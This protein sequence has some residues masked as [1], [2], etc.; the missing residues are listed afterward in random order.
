MTTPITTSTTDSQMHN[1]IMA[2]G[3]R[4]RP[5]ML[6]TRPNGEALSKFILEGP[7]KLTTITIPA[8]HATDDT[9]AVPERTAEAIHLLRTG[10]GDEIYSTVDAFKI[11]HDIWIAIERLQQDPYYQAPKSQKAYATHPKQPSSTRSSETTNYKGK[12]IAKPIIP[13]SE[14]ASEEDSDPE[15]AQRDK[16][17]QKNLALIA[18]YFKKIYKPTNNNLITSSNSRKKNVDT[19]PRYKN[20]NQSG[21]FGNQK[22]VT[23][24]GARETICSQVVQRTRIQCYNSK[25]FGHFAKECRKPKRVKDYVYHK[26][27][28]LLCCCAG[29]R[30]L[31]QEVLQLPRL[32]RLDH[33]ITEF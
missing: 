19:S 8:V 32:G 12:E 13:Q 3:S 21:Q 18:K 7:Y 29:R 14:S 1:N 23:V 9:S 26:E 16:E 28:M 10:I 22:T 11:A 4:D 24:A 6:D 27:K 5:P 20:D 33:G 15:Q 2:A 25:E 31:Q 30:G 17:M